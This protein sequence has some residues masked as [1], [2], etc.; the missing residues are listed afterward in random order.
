MVLLTALL[1]LLWSLSTLNRWL[2]LSE[3]FGSEGVHKCMHLFVSPR[4]SLE[5][6]LLQVSKVKISDHIDLV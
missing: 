2:L 3:D 1:A 4:C 5:S 6:N